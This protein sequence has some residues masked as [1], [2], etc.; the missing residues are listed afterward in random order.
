MTIH[1]MKTGINYEPENCPVSTVKLQ[2]F[3]PS[4]IINITTYEDD[5][6]ENSSHYQKITVLDPTYYDD[7]PTNN[8]SGYLIEH[9]ETNENYS[10]EYL[11]TEKTSTLNE[12][13]FYTYELKYDAYSLTS[14]DVLQLYK[15]NDTIVSENMYKLEYGTETLEDNYYDQ[16]DV[17]MNRYGSGI[18]WSSFNSSNEVHRVRILLPIDVSNEYDFYTVR[19]NKR[20]L[21]I[22]NPSHVELLEY[23]NLYSSNDFTVNNDKIEYASNS[24]LPRNNVSKL[25][26]IKDPRYIINSIGVSSLQ[27]SIYQNDVDT[28]WN[29]KLSYGKFIRNSDYKGNNNDQFAL[30][31]VEPPWTNKDQ[32]QPVVYIKPKMLNSNV[33]KVDEKPVYIDTDK[34]IYPDY[35]IDIYPRITTDTII[36]TGTFA[37]D[38][39]GINDTDIKISSIDRDKGY[40]LFNKP[41]PPSSEVYLHYY[42]NTTRE[43]L[44][45]NLELNP[46]ISG[47]YGFGNESLNTIKNIGIAVRK[48]PAAGLSSDYDTEEVYL[49]PYFFDFDNITSEGSG[50]FYRGNPIPG[51][52]SYPVS[53]GQLIW[54]PYSSY[55]NVSG[56]YMPLCHLSVNKMTPNLLDITDARVIGGGLDNRSIPRLDNNQ[57]NS[58]ADLGYYDGEPLPHSSLIMIHFPSGLFETHISAWEN[59]NMFSPDAYTDITRNEVDVL[60]GNTSGTYRE[61]YNKLLAGISPTTGD[62]SKDPYVT[63]RYKWAKKQASLYIDQLIKKYISAGTQYILLDSNFNEIRLDKDVQEI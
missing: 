22:N 34:Y 12:P 61:Y 35:E 25:Y 47:T 48:S 30:E 20:V 29:L 5:I 6:H 56:E 11:I 44:L 28:Q 7:I 49:N 10:N 23:K 51:G 2:G 40:I 37:I 33:L 13:L 46:K 45:R 53:S 24:T 8:I 31:Y 27:N 62:Q 14:T 50:V 58:Y 32:Y 38:V 19:Y 4:K 59:S 60:E 26:T 39:D 57:L 18:S 3:S 43:F 21:S 55:S 9:Y 54:N 63:M 17:D 15:N 36:A 42:I 16:Q 41:I 52:T 1:F